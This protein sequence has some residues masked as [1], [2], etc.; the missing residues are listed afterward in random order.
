MLA[1]D[2]KPGAIFKQNDAPYIVESVTVQ[3]PSAR[4]GNT[5]YKFRARH[6][7][8]KQKTDL[9]CKGTDNLADADFTKRLVSLMYQDNEAVH[10]L[11]T[12]T[13]EQ[14]SIASEDV[15][16]EMSYVT[17]GLEGMFALIY[18]DQCVGL[19]VPAAVA[20]EI[21]ECDPGAKGNSATGRTKSA[22]LS[23][24]KTIQVPE[25][26]KQGEVIKVDTRT[27]EFLGRA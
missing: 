22:T 21:T 27:G 5:L 14:Y 25:Y 10:L 3:S 16:E 12:E 26:L 7:I 6:L 11:D 17:E 8:T 4:G 18:E 1:K 24:G 20:L 23:T 2:L 19:Q 13:Y 15:A 9:T